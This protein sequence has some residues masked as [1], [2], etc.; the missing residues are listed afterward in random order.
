[1]SVM[2]YN[3]ILST[4]NSK[5]YF[6]QQCKTVICIRVLI[7]LGGY[8]MSTKKEVQDAFKKKVSDAQTAIDESM[9]KY[10]E[11][12]P[13]I[14]EQRGKLAQGWRI[15]Y[16]EYIPL[17]QCEKKCD[18]LVLTANQVE[19]NTFLRLASA[20]GEKP[21]KTV[22]IEDKKF[23]CPLRCH[24][25]KIAE[26]N[27]VHI[28]TLDTSSDTQYGSRSAIRSA[29]KTFSPKMV[30]SLG[31]AF[32]NDPTKQD[33]GDVIISEVL[34]CYSEKN[35][36]MS[37]DISLKP[38]RFH[39]IDS[40]LRSAFGN[41]LSNK[42]YPK[43]RKKDFK[44]HFGTVLSGA[45]VVDNLE[46]KIKLI[47]ACKSN[48]YDNV[49]GGEMEGYG[50]F[51]ECNYGTHTP[52]I[53][54]KGI[55]D[56]A[57]EKNN[58]DKLA[59]KAGL[60]VPH[61]LDTSWNNFLK[62]GAQ[63]FATENAFHALELLLEFGKIPLIH[64]RNTTTTSSEVDN[65]SRFLKS[66]AEKMKFLK[67]MS[68]GV[69]IMLGLWIVVLYSFFLGALDKF[70]SPSQRVMASVIFLCLFIFT[71]IY[72]VYVLCIKHLFYP[73]HVD[74]EAAEI[75]ISV[76]DFQNCYCAIQNMSSNVLRKF[77]VTWINKH[78]GVLVCN[79][80]YFEEINRTPIT[81]G[82]LSASK[83]DENCLA[84][85]CGTVKPDTIQFEYDLYNHRICHVIRCGFKKEW[86]KSCEY[87]NIYE[88]IYLIKNGKDILLYKR[89]HDGFV[90][91]C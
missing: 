31:V 37:S 86:R 50:A 3:A 64:D 22:V 87:R 82:Y 90:C 51:Y 54:I 74:I 42:S 85:Y 2:V 62:D 53:V 73:F 56:W 66:F 35:K 15:E 6:V 14:I 67:N 13:D 72:L 29:L 83:A 24:M 69:V 1:M 48:N 11:I 28:Q 26:T 10:F 4:L 70:V 52:F 27:I 71:L 38:D 17:N 79:R 68:K 91:K 49:V 8:M 81:I 58:W 63:G 65:I 19:A 18:V 41:P 57:A 88:Y 60:Q 20:H 89:K 5:L 33:F 84:P 76:L 59:R 39:S 61:G 36:I 30:V 46:L 9:R 16:E 78:Q 40:I 75:K 45:S 47:E 12:S 55:C 77:R 80:I 43:E 23:D 34:C 25:C 32:G 21:L 44:W 7:N